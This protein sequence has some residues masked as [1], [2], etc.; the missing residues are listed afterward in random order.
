MHVCFWP[1]A[2]KA[3]LE[4]HPVQLAIWANRRKA[5]TNI[6]IVEFTAFDELEAMAD[7]KA[8]RSAFFER[9]NFNRERSRI[10]HFENL[11][12]NNRAYA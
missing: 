12:K 8:I 6:I 3:Y 2:C 4:V 11:S 1:R 10:C 9:S 5:L 7:V